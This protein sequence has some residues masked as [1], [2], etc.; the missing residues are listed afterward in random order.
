MSQIVFEQ[1]SILR[2]P[3][4]R[5]QKEMLKF[6]LTTLGQLLKLL[7]KREL[8]KLLNIQEQALGVGLQLHI[9]IWLQGMFNILLMFKD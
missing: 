8:F 6:E 1:H 4:H 5:F 3:L 9:A 2:Q 7:D